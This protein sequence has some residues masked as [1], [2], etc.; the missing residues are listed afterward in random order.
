MSRLILPKGEEDSQSF[1]ILNVA[2]NMHVPKDTANFRSLM[3]ALV[4]LQ[5]D[6][7]EGE[8]YA[9]F[10]EKHAGDCVNYDESWLCTLNEDKDWRYDNP[11]LHHRVK[12]HTFTS[13]DSL[14][15]VRAKVIADKAS[16]DELNVEFWV[17]GI[18]S[19]LGGGSISF[20]KQ[21]DE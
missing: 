7:W 17:N 3:E 16:V 6:D 10:V 9:A 2:Y 20:T 19:R 13:I 5:I 21:L 11:A 1:E 8:K 4:A 18:S 15:S 12:G 14:K